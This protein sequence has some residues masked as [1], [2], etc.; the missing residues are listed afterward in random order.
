MTWRSHLDD[1]G[2]L[3][4]LA[5]D[6]KSFWQSKGTEWD[7][8]NSKLQQVIQEEQRSHLVADAE[9]TQRLRELLEHQPEYRELRDRLDIEIHTALEIAAFLDYRQV[10]SIAQIAFDPPLPPGPLLAA[11]I[12][13]ADALALYVEKSK[14]WQEYLKAGI[15]WILRPVFASH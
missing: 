10:Q 13:E 7:L 9:P 11:A 8:L 3:Y 14:Y 15:R 6:L 12:D 4:S 2:V 5:D 1:V